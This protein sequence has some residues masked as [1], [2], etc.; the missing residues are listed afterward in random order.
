M[1]N[2]MLTARRR[3]LQCD[4][5]GWCVGFSGRFTIGVWSENAEAAPRVWTRLFARLHADRWR[6]ADPVVP[7]GLAKARVDG[8]DEW[9]LEGTLPT[10]R[11]FESKISYPLRGSSI[12]LSASE[13]AGARS[14]YF[15]VA[16]PGADQ[17]LYLNGVR[18][19][20]A[21]ALLP[22]TA[23]AGSHVLELRDA[24]GQTLD[25]VRFVVR[26]PGIAQ[27]P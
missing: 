9:F 17:N 6:D 15:H 24:R 23:Q 3:V 21:R 25:E 22:W 27:A 12:A 18:L 2:D 11:V 14:L 1:V 26:S 19:G 16:S 20:R 10:P 8:R 4:A 7:A 13:A 5:D